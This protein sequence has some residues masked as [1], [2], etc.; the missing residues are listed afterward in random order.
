M[1]TGTHANLS[2]KPAFWAWEQNRHIRVGAKTSGVLRSLT[3]VKTR[4][5]LSRVVPAERR[6]LGL[7][8]YPGTTPKRGRG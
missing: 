8:N 1:R 5:N 3:S 7:G 4:Q 6:R 2:R